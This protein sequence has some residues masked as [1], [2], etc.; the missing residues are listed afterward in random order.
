MLAQTPA[1]G[2]PISERYDAD[3]LTEH[4]GIQGATMLVDVLKTK[5]FVPPL[6]DVGWYKD[7]GG[8]VDH[9]GKIVKADQQVDLSTT[10]VK[11]LSA[12]QRA[13]G[14]P[15][16]LLP[17]GERLILNQFRVTG[18]DF[19]PEPGPPGL[20]VAGGTMPGQPQEIP[21]ARLACGGVVAI[22]KCTFSGGAIGGGN[23]RL[24]K[25][26]GNRQK[27]LPSQPKL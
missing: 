11:Q 10:T 21:V 5:V 14:D 1:P 7:S 6:R 8:P 18:Y 17:S 22:L 13:I 26:L 27:P 2:I 24:M 3:S 19:Q 23:Q 25:I 9:A 15:W 16:C 12:I 20:W 4:L